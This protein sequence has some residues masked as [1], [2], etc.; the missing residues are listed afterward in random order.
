MTAYNI[1]VTV[2][3]NIFRENEEKPSSIMRHGVYYDAFI[4]MIENVD[5]MFSVDSDTPEIYDNK[6][7]SQ[8]DEWTR[9]KREAKL[10]QE[11][12]KLQASD[13]G[14]VGDQKKLERML[15]LNRISGKTAAVS[16]DQ[17]RISP[18]GD[19]ATKKKPAFATSSDEDIFAQI[20]KVD[21]EAAERAK[22]E[23][24]KEKEE[25][26]LSTILEEQKSAD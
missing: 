9:V 10:K 18:H 5:T 22:A 26:Q 12:E 1:A 7:N 4:R 13:V 25:N 20:D 17:Y 2:G 23:E 11:E 14:A 19:E 3:P 16:D 21:R 24:E 6:V 15:G 8:L